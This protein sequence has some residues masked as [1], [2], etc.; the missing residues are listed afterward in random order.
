LRTHD[1]AEIAEHLHTRNPSPALEFEK[2][3]REG[4]VGSEFM[5]MDHD[6]AIGVFRRSNKKFEFPVNWGV[7]LQS[8][9]ERYL[10]EKYAKRPVILIN[11]LRPSKPSTC[12]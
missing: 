1:P 12:G 4:I 2:G 10:T 8:E 7:D 5:H 11:Y 6:E 9:H 3:C